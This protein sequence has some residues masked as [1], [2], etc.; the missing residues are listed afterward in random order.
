MAGHSAFAN[1]KHRKDRQDAKRGK[2]W[3]KI[4]KSIIVAAQ[5]G[6]GDPNHNPRLRLA[7]AEAKAAQMPK[8]N[9]DRAIK[10]GIGEL[11]GGKMEEGSYEG[12][13]PG[14]IAVICETMTDN[15]NRTA[16]EIRKI[17]DVYGGNLGKSNCVGY[18]FDR[19]GLFLI[20]ADKVPEET[21]MELVLDAGA[22]DLKREGD[23]YQVTT[24][25]DTYAAVSEALEK[26]NIPVEA[27]QL[28]K[29]PQNTVEIT[30][31]DKA[32][33]IAKFME[34]LDDHDDVQNVWSNFTIAEG[35]DVS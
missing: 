17:F 27:K 1:I 34:A 11:D 14:G 7:I 18:M 16:P 13:G 20:A 33:S 15:V 22:E 3:T 35:I 28:A 2:V 29:V 10:R 21:L 30:D 24:P 5:L 4:S 9:I 19:K 12:Y 6:G 32:K 8:D 23:K 31:P 25:P 26:A